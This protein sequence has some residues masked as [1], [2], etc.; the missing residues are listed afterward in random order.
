MKKK[1][2]RHSRIIWLTF[3]LLFGIC[4][5]AGG[6]IAQAQTSTPTPAAQEENPTPVYAGPEF[7]GKCH[8]ELFDTWTSTRHAEA[9]SSPIFQQDWVK[10]GSSNT[11]LECHTTGYDK[12]NGAFSHEGVTCESCHGAFQPGH[13]QAIMP[14]TPDA[15]LCSTCHQ[16]TTNEWHASPHAAA[17]IQCQA[18]HNPHSQTP[19]AASVTELCTNCHK[20]MGDSFAH[21]T[22]AESGV[23]CSNCHMYT[24][25][26]EEDAV[27]GLV[28]TGHTFTV[29]S[30]ACI[31][32]HQ[33]TVHTRDTIVKLSGQ[34]EASPVEDTRTLEEKIVEQQ[35]LIH[36]LESE[37]TVRLYTGLAQGAIVGLVVGGVAAWVVS[38]RITIVEEEEDEQEK[39][40]S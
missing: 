14:I 17:N 34:V 21:S 18:C 10:E 8:Q 1:N 6:G 25:P 7:C 31:G 36:D 40:E 15:E 9:F 38:K 2:F 29:G 3:A 13:P 12:E 37:R 4:L 39:D 19:R 20:D 30:E 24:P 11:C 23:E 16:S 28:P 27:M 35:T 33:D 26:R 32:C 22:H 5:L